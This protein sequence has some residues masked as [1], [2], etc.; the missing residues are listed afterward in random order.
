[1]GPL[2]RRLLSS[3]ATRQAACPAPAGAARRAAALLAV[4]GLAT[5]L[6]APPAEAR[7]RFGPRAVFGILT[8]PL[9]IVGGLAGRAAYPH[10]RQRA[11]RHGRPSAPRRAPAVAAAAMGAL[12]AQAS[13][14]GPV[15]WPDGFADM[16]GYA[17]RSEGAETRFWTAGFA[18]VVAGVL[19]PTAPEGGTARGRTLAKAG[20]D[21]RTTGAGSDMPAPT[22]CAASSARAADQIATHI[23]QTAPPTPEQQ[24]A[25]ASLRTALA[26]AGEMLVRAC[27]REPVMTAPARLAA[28]RER[29]WAMQSAALAVR[30]PLAAFRDGL[31]NAQKTKL[32]GSPADDAKAEAAAKPPARMKTDAAT[33][34]QAGGAGGVVRLCHLQAQT[35]SAQAP[36]RLRAGLTLDKEQQASL[37]SLTDLSGGMAKFMVASCPADPPTGAVARLDAALGRLDAMLY[38][39]GVVAPPL[40]G[41]YGS[42]SDEQKARF[43]ALGGRTES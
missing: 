15:F 22:A 20:G 37:K 13:W 11:L 18:D 42:L 8:A 2:T 3:S 38:A 12:A 23:A 36:A 28:M 10:Y 43:D 27:P 17:A 19:A 6:A 39:L 26:Q 5:V 40:Q 4:A 21:D 30:G 33:A 1:M 14:A 24:E 7:P 41:F 9:G 34:A 29:L 35:A 25:F 31:D 16:F 32:D